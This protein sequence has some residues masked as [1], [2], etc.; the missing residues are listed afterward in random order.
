MLSAFGPR[1]PQVQRQLHVLQRGQ[2]GE[3][4]EALEDEADVVAAERRSCRSPVRRAPGRQSRT[5][6]L[7]AP[8]D[9]AHDREQRRLAAAGRTHEQ[10]ISPRKMSRSTS[11]DRDALPLRLARRS[12]QIAGDESMAVSWSALEHHGGI[13]ARDLVDR[14]QR[15][16]THIADREH[17]HA[18]TIGGGTRIAAPP[19]WLPLDRRSQLTPI[20]ST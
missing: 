4:V 8:Q 1:S 15:C 20:A 10:V 16:P 7:T 2:R 11:I 5:L 14:D 19:L 12:C 13:E 18:A 6:P 3:Q 17:E 9:A